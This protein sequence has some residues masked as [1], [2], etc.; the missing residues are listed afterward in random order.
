ML[1]VAQSGNGVNRALYFVEG[2]SLQVA[3]RQLVDKSHVTLDAS[4]PCIL[5]N[6]GGD[7][8]EVCAAPLQPMG[9]C[10]ALCL[11]VCH[12]LQPPRVC[13]SHSSAAFVSCP[14]AVALDIIE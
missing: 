3:G 8:C 1:Q 10:A 5:Q 11:T 13:G 12:P 2:A 14:A 4:K 6:S 7:T 9:L